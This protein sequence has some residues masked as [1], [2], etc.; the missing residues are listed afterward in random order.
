[1]NFNFIYL[2]KLLTIFSLSI[3]ANNQANAFR[4]SSDVQVK[5]IPYK[6]TQ[7][8][9]VQVVTS[10]KKGTVLYVTP[11]PNT[12]IILNSIKVRDYKT[13]NHLLSIKGKAAPKKIGTR[14]TQILNGPF[15][16]SIGHSSPNTLTKT[17]NIS[18]KAC[19]TS[20]ECYNSINRK[21]QLN[22]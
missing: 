18:Y 3:L 8:G 17:L 22:D 21:V 11:P 10:G 12:F 7:Q 5:S 2:S 6:L 1:M 14:I 9:T 16:V 19:R 15:K 13:S 20:Y 4:I